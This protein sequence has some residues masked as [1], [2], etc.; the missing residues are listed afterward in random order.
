M[1]CPTDPERRCEWRDDSP[2][3]RIELM[4][5]A[6]RST[7]SG[8]EARRS[9]WR[10]RI[11]PPISSRHEDSAGYCGRLATQL[12]VLISG[13]RVLSSPPQPGA[14]DQRRQIEKQVREAEVV[15][16]VIGSRWAGEG[17]S[18]LFRHAK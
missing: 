18:S 17:G 5:T 9:L 4:K 7:S 1:R 2:G 13:L 6:P 3:H 12:K 10:S 11:F 15:L 16:A 8:M 14:A